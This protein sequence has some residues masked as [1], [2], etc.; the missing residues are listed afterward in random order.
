LGTPYKFGPQINTIFA[1]LLL[2]NV[3]TCRSQFNFYLLNFSSTDSSFYSSNISSFLVWSKLVYLAVLL[4]KINLDDCQLFFYRF[5]KTLS[6][7]SI[8]KFQ[9]TTLK[10]DF[11]AP[12]GIRTKNSSKLTAVEPRLRT[13]GHRVQQLRN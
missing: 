5:S 11:F 6:F 4:E 7:A 12:G 2:F 8:R 13:R 9:N 1:I 3:F 10:K